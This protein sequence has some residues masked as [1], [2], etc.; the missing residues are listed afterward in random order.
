MVIII[1]LLLMTAPLQA[2][3]TPTAGNEY[4]SIEYGIMRYKKRLL[5]EKELLEKEYANNPQ[6]VTTAFH[7]AEICACLGD[8]DQAFYV[9]EQ[10]ANRHE[11]CEATFL[12]LCR[13]GTMVEQSDQKNGKESWPVALHYYLK[14]HETLPERAEPLI[15][16]AQHYAADG[17][18]KLAYFFARIASLLPYPHDALYTVE[19]ELYTY[20][21]Y[22]LL[23]QY[24]W[25]AQAFE[26]GEW[27][28]R[29]ALEAKPDHEHLK[30]N[31][32]FYVDRK[33][34]GD[35]RWVDFIESM[36][37]G[38]AFNQ[39]FLETDPWAQQLQKQYKKF[40]ERVVQPNETVRIP[41]IIHQIWLGSS[42]PPKCQ[43]LQASW[44]AHHPDWEYRLWTDKDVEEFGLKNKKAYDAA[45]TYGEKSDIARYEI[46]YHLGGL[47]VDTDFECV[48]PFDILH[49]TCDFYAGLEGSDCLVGNSLIGSVAGSPILKRCID[50]LQCAA[51]G[52]SG[53]Q[54]VAARTG[55]G[56]ITRCVKGCVDQ[57]TVIFPTGYFFPWY[58]YFGEVRTAEKALASI[59]PETFGVH[60]W[61]SSW[62]K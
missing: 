7:L 58:P 43:A 32:Q 40:Q 49:Q 55:P 27:A 12:A 20:V 51:P 37:H 5:Q 41:K 9:Y 39:S 4:P 14:A 36:S 33:A 35:N 21:R 62:V 61:H 19:K 17:N 13:L 42:L 54:Y 18:V 47:Y 28:M 56:H 11:Q 59:R 2:T 46:L 57:G 16:L 31:L 38:N 6:S 1:A 23:G 50:T 29:K 22:D 24:A 30:R 48:R 10:C 26:V 34:R 3:P 44:L 52:E 60:H 45:L 25:Y 8:R 53:W 15:K